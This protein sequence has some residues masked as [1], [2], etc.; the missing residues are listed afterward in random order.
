MIGI[1][2]V[3]VSVFA[4]YT[5]TFGIMQPRI[6]RGV[7]LLFLL[8]MAFILFPASKK[9]ISDKIP[10]YDWILAFLSLLPALYVIIQNDALSMRFEFVEPL[11]SLE[12]V[13]GA[14]NILLLLEAIRRAVVPAMAILI[15]AFIAYLYAAPHL[16]GVF[17]AKPLPL[18]EIIEMQFLITDAGI[19][20][21]ITGI[22]AT[23]VA[24]MVIFGAI[25]E[26]TQTGKFFTDL[27]CRLAGKSR[28]G[29]AK[30]AVISSAF[31][32]SISGV[33]AANVYATGTFTI[34]MM[35][36]L[37]Y[38]PQFAG[39]VEAVSSSGG[40]YMPP[41][42]GA[43]VFVMSEITGIPYLEICISAV[44]PA[45]MYYASLVARVHFV[46]LRDNLRGLTEEEMSV[47]LSVIL[48]DAYL[49]VPLVGLVALLVAGYSV[50]KAAMGAI[51]ISYVI[52]FFKKKTAMTPRRLLEALRAA[53][54]NMVMIAL[55][56]A[57]AG[58]VVAIVTHTG[59]ALGI[60]SV[61]TNWS[62]GNLQPALMLIMVTSLVLGMGMPCTPAYIIAITIG[63]PALVGMGIDLQAAH[64]F[65]FYFAILA[66]VTPPV[67]IP[68]YCAASIAGSHPLQTGFEA[69]K[70][71]L[72]AFV[73][74]YVYVYNQALLL[75]G[76]LVET[77]SLI[78]VMSIA[79]IA[80][81]AAYSG[82]F[83]KNLKWLYRGIMAA[84]GC[85]LIYVCALRDV[86]GQPITLVAATSILVAF[87]L[88]TAA[89]SR[90][91]KR[92]APELP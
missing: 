36:K 25:M 73:I 58:M 65:V 38:R 79:I 56:C 41:I 74:P 47:P 45:L 15:G 80:F 62:G 34:P 76:G 87:L 9:A 82:F 40:Q 10:G 63:G 81:S 78:L 75:K 70:L 88:F 51:A 86:V 44:L 22:S 72:I 83:F 16:S 46:A 64:L 5:A 59:L 55:A 60:A 43:G 11:T 8:P 27:A 20:G 32:G 52:S 23:F 12:M 77:V 69:F 71:A 50:F 33:A 24:L 66:E 2:L 3:A 31:F 57:G 14:L 91:M 30:V 29:P 89:R 17:Y 21:S 28:G 49:L 37:G 26:G 35:K 4:L 42:M 54:Q 1:W 7:H 90:K 6:Q 68:A 85:V 84:A 48:K 19:Y 39:A 18:S 92:M 13:L 53:G 67:C 61:I